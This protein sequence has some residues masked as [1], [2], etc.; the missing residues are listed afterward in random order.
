MTNQSD[1]KPVRK[2]DCVKKFLIGLSMFCM[3]LFTFVSASK[4]ALDYS[5][6]TPLWTNI[7]ILIG[8]FMLGVALIGGGML[9]LK[10]ANDM[11]NTM[12]SNPEMVTFYRQLPSK[13]E[14][15]ESKLEEIG[16]RLGLTDNPTVLHSL[17][18][19]EL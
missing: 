14:L 19:T 9:V 12:K 3:G 10:Q 18:Q 1:I 11:W 7:L 6:N 16:T 8:M 17:P 15:L 13:I 5:T 4:I 2:I